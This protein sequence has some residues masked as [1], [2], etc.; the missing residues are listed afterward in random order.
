M[1]LNYERGVMPFSGTLA[2]QPNKI[3]E[4]L[5]I[6]DTIRKERSKEENEKASSKNKLKG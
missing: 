1:Y 2:D 3:I 4:V 6:I 5:H